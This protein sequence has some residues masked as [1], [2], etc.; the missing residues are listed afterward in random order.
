VTPPTQGSLV[1]R[2][3]FPPSLILWVFLIAEA[4]EQKIFGV[5]IRLKRQLVSRLKIFSLII[6]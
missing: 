4:G 5:K 3:G 1:S 2:E 6:L